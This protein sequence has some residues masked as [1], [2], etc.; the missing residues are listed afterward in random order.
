MPNNLKPKTNSDGTQASISQVS[1]L[2]RMQVEEKVEEPNEKKVELPEREETSEQPN[3]I[4]GTELENML[5]EVKQQRGLEIERRPI[6][7]D[8]E[9]YEIFAMLKAKKRVPAAGLVSKICRKWILQNKS[10]LE[11]MLGQKI[12]LQ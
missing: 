12:E 1:K 8:V 2:L 11:E 3:L 9:V 7:V 10:E 5:L 6:V 4:K